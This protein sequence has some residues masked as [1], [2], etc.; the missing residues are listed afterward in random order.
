MCLR[1]KV[2]NMNNFSGERLRTLRMSA[3]LSQKKLAEQLNVR[4]TT[5]SRIEKGEREPSL[6]LLNLIADFFNVSVDYLLGRT[7]DPTPKGK[8][9]NVSSYLSTNVLKTPDEL[10]K[11]GKR[12]IE[13]A[14][15]LREE[16]K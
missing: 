16:F 9:F 4:H 11:L 2:V 1:V 10:E 14:N 3:G 6:Q 12:L 15:E 8:D 7:D 5:I 13:I